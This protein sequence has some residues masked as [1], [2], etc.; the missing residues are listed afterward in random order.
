MARVTRLKINCLHG[1]FKFQEQRAGEVSDFISLF[2]LNLSKQDDFFTFDALVD[3]PKYS[4]QGESYLDAIA[5]ENF[6]GKPWEIFKANELVYNY[7][8]GLVQPL[9]TIVQIVTLSASGNFY[10]S[11]GLILPGSITDGGSRIIDYAAW[12]TIDT[13]KF[14]Y[15][16]VGFV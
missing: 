12:V 1:Y 4:I 16:E 9:E 13:M 6:E 15:S 11:P 7:D 3:A 5:I 8:T 14:K 2:G 10:L